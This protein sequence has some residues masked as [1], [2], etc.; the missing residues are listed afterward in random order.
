MILKEIIFEKIEF[1]PDWMEVLALATLKYGLEINLMGKSID[2]NNLFKKADKANINV[3]EH[4]CNSLKNGQI[5]F[6]T[7]SELSRIECCTK[8]E[9]L[10]ILDNWGARSTNDLRIIPSLKRLNSLCLIGSYMP[11]ISHWHIENWNFL[12]AEDGLPTLTRLKICGNIFSSYNYVHFP[13]YFPNLEKLVVRNNSS[14]GDDFFVSLGKLEKL[15]ALY[16]FNCEIIDEIFTTLQHKDYF[17]YSV[18]YSVIPAFATLKCLELL[19]ISGCYKLTDAC[20]IDGVAKSSTLKLLALLCSSAKINAQFTVSGF[21][22]I[23]ETGNIKLEFNPC[24]PDWVDQI[25]W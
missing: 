22:A 6:K 10:V 13:M 19:V 8:L 25:F 11:D 20:L 21:D 14:I 5:E 4:N 24:L 1:R 18:T 12:P 3:N 15:K 16:I 17:P 7:P 23:K 2:L 9:K